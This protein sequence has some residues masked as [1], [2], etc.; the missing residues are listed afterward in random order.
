MYYNEIINNGKDTFVNKISKNTGLSKR[1]VAEVY[2]HVF[3]DKHRLEKKKKKVYPNYY[4]AVS[5]QRLL[6]G[7]YNDADIILLHHEHIERAVEKSII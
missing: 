5:F 6:Q 2:D 7:D 1:F 3:V 4:M